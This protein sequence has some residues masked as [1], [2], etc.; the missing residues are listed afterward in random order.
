MDGVK[1]GCRH[2]SSA[3]E[4]AVRCADTEPRNLRSG[5]LEGKGILVRYLRLNRGYSSIAS[6][7][8][9][10]YSQFSSTGL[11]LT[12]NAKFFLLFSSGSQCCSSFNLRTVGPYCLLVLLILAPL[13]F[14]A[15][16]LPKLELQN[17]RFSLLFFSFPR[18]H[19]CSTLPF[20]NQVSQLQ[21]RIPYSAIKS[22][23]FHN[24]PGAS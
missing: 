18:S 14:S 1:F 6:P 4:I 16:P 7:D 10:T 23:S 2:I 12:L 22:H 15:I 5:K 17:L 13:I 24:A 3:S 19:V 9:H 8:P 11:T 20:N 21:E